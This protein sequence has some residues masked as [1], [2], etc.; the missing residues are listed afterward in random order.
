MMVYWRYVVKKGRRCCVRLVERDGDIK[1][2]L[3]GADGHD[4]SCPY[5]EKADPSPP[6][7]EGATGFGMTIGGKARAKAA[8]EGGACAKRREI[9][10]SARDDT[11]R[12]AE[13]AP[14]RFKKAI[15][16]ALGVDFEIEV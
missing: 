9:P 7:A 11:V 1:S 3:Q 14:N 2:P 8:S 5:S 12:G 4:M 16:L 10:R 13:A 6:F 15:T